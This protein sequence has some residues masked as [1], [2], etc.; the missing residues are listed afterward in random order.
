[1]TQIDRAK[2]DLRNR[3]SAQM[4]FWMLRF[5]MDVKELAR[6]TGLAENSIY[7]LRR[8]EAGA[9]TNSIAVIADAFQVPAQVLLMPLPPD[10]EPDDDE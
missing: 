1:M 8:A 10:N 7:R 4:K 3:L 9:T 5:N 6:L 2:M